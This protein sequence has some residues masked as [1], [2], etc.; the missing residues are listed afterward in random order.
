MSESCSVPDAKR[1][2]TTTELD[3]LRPDIHSFSNF[4]QFECT[5]IDLDVS[6]DFTDKVF[7]GKVNLTFRVIDNDAKQLM[8]DVESLNITSV[9]GMEYKIGES[10]PFGQELVLEI[11]D[12]VKDSLKVEI[13]YTTDKKAPGIQ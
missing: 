12:G 3:T 2:K 10:G 8:L 9:T 11:P 1:A 5:Q 6:I 7:K 13:E 4:K